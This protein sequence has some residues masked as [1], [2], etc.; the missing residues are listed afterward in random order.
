MAKKGGKR[1]A[2]K[3]KVATTGRGRYKK[4][5]NQAPFYETGDIMNNTWEK[6]LK[7]ANN[8]LGSQ[9]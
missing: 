5:G 1:S 2:K 3:V 9:L 8:I 7:K 4:Y 6:N